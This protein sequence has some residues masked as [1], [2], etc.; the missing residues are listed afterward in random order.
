MGGVK[1][2]V[3]I[4]GFTSPIDPLN[5][6]NCGYSNNIF[7]KDTSGAM[8]YGSSPH[9]FIIITLSNAGVG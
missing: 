1:I 5:D 6:F 9:K 7:E 2:V 4:G 8:V 3:M